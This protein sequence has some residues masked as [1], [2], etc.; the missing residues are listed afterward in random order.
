MKKIIILILLLSGSIFSQVVYE[1]LHRDVYDYLSRLSQKDFFTFDDLIRPVSRQY[2]ATKL[3]DAK[4]Q[5]EHLTSLEKEELSFYLADFQRE[6]ELLTEEETEEQFGYFGKDYGGRYRLLWYKDDLFTLNLSP[7]YGGK[8]GLRDGEKYTYFWNGVYL[9]GYIS[10]FLGYSFDFRDNVENGT[11]INKKKDF[12][13]LTGTNE[14]NSRKNLNYPDDQVEYSEVTTSISAGWNWGS[15]SIGKEFFEWGYGNSGLL[16]L[17]QKAPSFPFIRLDIKPVDW[18]Q[19]DYI[20]GWLNSD[21][22]DSSASYYNDLGAERI[23]FRNKFYA[24]H[25][26]SVTPT[27]GLNISLGE[28]IVYSD[29]LEIAYLIPLMFFRLA[30]HFLS[31]QLNNAGSNAQL[32]ASVSSRGHIKNTHIYSTLFIDEITLSNLFNSEKQRNQFGFTFGSSVVDIPFD[33][34]KLNFEFTRI[35]PFV[36]SHNIGTTTYKSDGYVLGHWMGSNADLVYGS[37]EYRFIRGLKTKVW[38]QYIRKGEEGTLEQQY[39]T[40]PQPPFLFG[41]RTNYTYLGAEVSYEFIHELFAKL[42]V[43]T[44]ET[45]EEQ[46][47][48]NFKE[49][50]LNEFY[51][52]VYYGL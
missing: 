16:V 48:G 36:Y 30:D 50:R 24:S 52:S 44:R 51:F 34:L 4:D 33:N 5:Y 1:P 31:E 8:F 23:V 11:T 45:S 47:S 19:F 37:L 6:V 26:V 27:D 28:S 9:Y 7:I 22:V 3:L 49:S 39:Q 18:L 25:T 41:L 12:T 46:E 38:A 35:Y 14:R 10:D 21:I 29:K 2:I 32:F 42:S 13:P 15:A 40:Q 17:S 43:Q 20:H